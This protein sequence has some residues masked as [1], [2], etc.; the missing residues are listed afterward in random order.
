MD[1]GGRIQEHRKAQV[2]QVRFKPTGGCSYLVL[3]FWLN[4]VI[5]LPA[6]PRVCPSDLD[7][8]HLQFQAFSTA[9]PSY[10]SASSRRNWRHPHGRARVGPA[11]LAGVLPSIW[12]ARAA[13]KFQGLVCRLPNGTTRLPTFQEEL[14]FW[15]GGGLHT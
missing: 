5:C 8:S 15:Y 9:E 7:D 10:H 1:R 3:V 6:T 4:T 12:I 13:T 14:K 11:P 2:G